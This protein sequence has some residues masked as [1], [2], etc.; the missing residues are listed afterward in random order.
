MQR[1]TQQQVW[2]RGYWYQLISILI[3]V[4]IL[5]SSCGTQAPSAQIIALSTQSNIIRS[6]GTLNISV[7]T[8]S[9]KAA[10]DHIELY[11]GV[12]PSRL[13]TTITQAPYEFQVPVVSQDAGE[14]I[15]T[16]KAYTSDGKVIESTPLE[17]VVAIDVPDPNLAILTVRPN[18][19]D[20]S[21]WQTT[22]AITAF[23][24]KAIEFY[25]NTIPIPSTVKGSATQYELQIP[26]GLSGNMYLWSRALVYGNFYI[27]SNKMPVSVRGSGAT[28]GAI[29]VNRTL[30]TE[31]DTLY[32]TGRNPNTIP[33]TLAE[34]YENGQK[35]QTFNQEPYK[36][37]KALFHKDNGNLRY[38]MRFYYADSQAV[39]TEDVYAY[40][41][42]PAV[43]IK[44]YAQ[45]GTSQ[46]LMKAELSDGL[47][48]DVPE[49][50]N[51]ESVKVSDN[52]RYLVDFSKMDV[53]TYKF[54]AKWN[55]NGKDVYSGDI[56][57]YWDGNILKTSML[58]LAQLNIFNHSK[59]KSIYPQYLTDDMFCAMNTAFAG[60]IDT[61]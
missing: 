49:I 60:F 2:D 52:S 23:Q 20:N 43:E 42:I 5:L 25:L 19:I 38:S 54:Y 50:Y 17:I 3:G 32:V 37:S 56:N 10:I 6:V 4:T 58:Q 22:L 26:S 51:E 24:P 61:C 40:V 41:N 55:S 57:F 31:N 18:I 11:R 9:I 8:A 53:G 14:Y 30:F 48:G 28:S 13:I 33:A 29:A 7:S 59:C 21:K 34:L 44:T 45:I 46:I 27:Y 36:Y 12:D 15:Y 1:V 47:S 35:I 39:Y 16:A